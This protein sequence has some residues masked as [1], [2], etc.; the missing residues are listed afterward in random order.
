MITFETAALRDAIK[1][2]APPTSDRASLPILSHLLIE[3]S[4][5]DVKI[6]GTDLQTR[7]TSSTTLSAVVG[8]ESAMALP[9]K[10]LAAIA[11]TASGDTIN[12]AP[13][14][15]HCVIKSG[16]SRFRVAMLPAAD[17]P[18]AP[19]VSGDIIPV[20]AASLKGAMTACAT[21]SAKDDVRYYLNGVLLSFTPGKI[22][23]VGTDGHRLC[24]RVIASDHA[25]E[26][27][28][29]VPRRSVELL[30]KMLIDADIV[31]LTLGESAMRVETASGAITIVLIEGK[32]PNWQQ[33]ITPAEKTVRVEKDALLAALTRMDILSDAAFHAC[34]IDIEKDVIKIESAAHTDS[35]TE[36]IECAFNGDP[37]KTGVS[38]EYLSAALKTLPD[39]IVNLCFSSENA[40]IFLRAPDIT[41]SEAGNLVSPVRT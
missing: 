20:N 24:W 1:A 39:G 32:Y 35:G 27:D 28:L 30:S 9:A 13:D 8:D 38:I 11:S 21:H 12:F 10:K 25:I 29:I 7:I 33:L 23:C 4:G 22:T 16:R 34:R 2:A 6:T 14:A 17:Y 36:E 19:P 3:Q 26:C 18:D 31:E 40:A 15:G 37:I 5:L 41:E